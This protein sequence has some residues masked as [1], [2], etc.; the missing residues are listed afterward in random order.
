MMSPPSYVMH[1]CSARANIHLTMMFS[2]CPLPHCPCDSTSP[3]DA[4][5]INVEASTAVKARHAAVEILVYQCTWDSEHSPCG[6][7]IEATP[8]DI[9]S[10]LRQHHGISH[11]AN[12]NLECRWSSCSADGPLKMGSISRHILKHLGIHFRCTGCELV[13]A[14]DDVV[15]A[16]IRRLPGCADAAV[17]LVPA[18]GARQI[19][20]A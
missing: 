12:E 10:H 16:H 5:V 17:Q 4:V 7:F 20:S 11:N 14:R 6:L 2:R 18:L 8:I 13:M 19:V 9:L 1:A 15:R 3:P